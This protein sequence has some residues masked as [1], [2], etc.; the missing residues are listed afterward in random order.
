[1]YWIEQL[2][3]LL[4]L[5]LPAASV[6]LLGGAAL[7]WAVAIRRAGGVGMAL[8]LLCVPM[9][10]ILLR[11]QARAEAF[12]SWRPLA[13]AIDAQLP[14]AVEIVFE[15]P[16]EYQ[17]VGGLA[18]YT[19]RRITILEPRGGFTPPTYL[20]A[21]R[22]TLFLSHADFAR[23]WAGREPLAFVSDPQRR[24]DRPDGLVPGPF[25]ILARSGDRWLLTNR[26][27]LVANA[28]E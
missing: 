13:R 16:Q 7:A 8:A 21:Y 27:P 24:R 9:L 5:V 22:D 14:A 25:H 28:P 23:R 1:M 10:T 26:H 3:A 15:A 2:P 12:F 19:R 4:G 11:A 18:F 17:Q 6:V 20:D